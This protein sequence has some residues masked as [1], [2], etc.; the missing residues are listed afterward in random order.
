[1]GNIL[2]VSITA[3]G[4]YRNENGKYFRRFYYGGNYRKE[5]GNILDVSITAAITEKNWKI[6]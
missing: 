3:G 5:L 4:N 2:D 1:L 6:C